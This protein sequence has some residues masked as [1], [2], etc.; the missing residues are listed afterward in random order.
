MR[1]GERREWASMRQSSLLADWRTAYLCHMNLYYITLDS[2]LRE[3]GLVGP[4]NRKR[5]APSGPER[6]GV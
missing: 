4:V 6:I 2:N 3:G 5:V 1:E